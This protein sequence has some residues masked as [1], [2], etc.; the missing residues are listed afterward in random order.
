MSASVRRLSQ[1]VVV[2]AAAL[3]WPAGQ[4]RGDEPVASLPRGVADPELKAGYVATSTLGIEGLSLENGKSL[5]KTA[6]WCL[7]LAYVD[8]QVLALTPD[9]RKPNVATVNAIDVAT[10]RLRWR[11]EP[12][13]FP[14][15]AAVAPAP[16]HGFG[17]VARLRGGDLWVKW[18]ARAWKPGAGKAGL[19]VE[20]GAA[21]VDLKT[22]KAEQLAADK[23][24]PPAVPAGLSKEL[25][26]KATRL[27]VT[28][29]GAEKVVCAVGGLAVAVD[30]DKDGVVLRRWDAKTEK[31]LEPVVLARGGPYVVKPF[32]A[33]GAVLVQPV[34]KAG[35]A[36]QPAVWQVFSLETGRLLLRFPVE[37]TAI[38]AEATILGPRIYYV[39]LEPPVKGPL[40][41]DPWARQ[42]KAV[43][44]RT[45]ALV[46][47]NHLD[48]TWDP[49]LGS[50][51]DDNP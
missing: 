6:S 18:R 2:L 13:A 15:W 32:P 11:S 1:A 16:E 20:D 5:F 19:K 9:P 43:D 31:A 40:S 26:Q 51:S 30:E 7:A 34:P 17:A 50:T 49:S 45:G 27:V 42:L 48:P 28:P 33:A 25:A 37:A 41:G 35:G 23:M 4:S 14:D 38:P 46:W 36:P 29:G 24:P 12:I 3:L 8:G 39:Y 21:R 47:S 22:H 10:G 44:L